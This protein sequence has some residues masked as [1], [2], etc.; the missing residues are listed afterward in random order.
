MR[1]LFEYTQ[2]ESLICERCGKSNAIH[3]HQRTMYESEVSNWVTLCE[4]CKEENDSYWD[5]KW[6]EYY[7]DCM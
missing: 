3:Y 5:E 4:S 2:S 1:K 6:E 7:R